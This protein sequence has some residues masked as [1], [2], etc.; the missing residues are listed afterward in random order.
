MKMIKNSVIEKIKQNII[1]MIENDFLEW[2]PKCDVLF[3]QPQRPILE[4]TEK[5]TTK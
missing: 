4:S 3:H 1:P 2:P 5:Q